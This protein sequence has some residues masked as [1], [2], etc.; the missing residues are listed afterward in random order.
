MCVNRELGC[1]FGIQIGWD[2]PQMGQVW[3]Q[4]QYILA[5]RA[6]LD[7]PGHERESITV[8]VKTLIENM[9]GPEVSGGLFQG[10]I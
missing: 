6:K 2:L 9:S 10:Q 3:D 7:I 4:F 1:Q 8:K 5:R